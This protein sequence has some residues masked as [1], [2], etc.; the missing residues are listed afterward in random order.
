MKLR[1]FSFVLIILI[2]LLSAFAV[3]CDGQ[4][5]STAPES[6]APQGDA[7]AEVASSGFMTPAPPSAE[8]EKYDYSDIELTFGQQK[9]K[10]LQF[11]VCSSLISENADGEGTATTADG[12]G[13]YAFFD[14][15]DADTEDL[16]RL[17]IDTESQEEFGFATPAYTF[18]KV[19]VEIYNGRYEPYESDVL[20]L[21]DLKKLPAGD[22][23]IVF[24]EVYE[25][26][27]TENGSRHEES[28]LYDCIFRLT[29]RSGEN[30]YQYSGV[31]L[32]SE[33]QAVNP[34]R[35]FVGGYEN[36]EYADGQACGVDMDG[37]GWSEIIGVDPHT[38]PVFI[39]QGSIELDLPEHTTLGSDIQLYTADYQPYGASSISFDE[40]DR[41]PPGEYV[42]VLSE[43]YSYSDGIVNIPEEEADYK[44]AVCFEYHYSY[45]S[46]FLLVVP[47][48]GK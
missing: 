4:T 19:P 29:V 13:R 47:E 7:E 21:E 9:I 17:I 20:T 36:Y 30:E 1:N 6:T 18:I 41:L 11:F 35:F 12:I 33:G 26:Q 32:R 42:A 44:G 27:Y 23:I 3:S 16:P 25:R 5:E 22:Y 24:G 8:T 46:V 2:L 34:M 14:A 28:V 15:S 39:W 10:P 37:G 31:T 48:V 45:D 38:L 40:F 43:R